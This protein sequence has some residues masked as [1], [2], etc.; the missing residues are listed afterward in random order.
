MLY[1]FYPILGGAKVTI[2]QEL[3]LSYYQQVADINPEHCVYLVQ[4]IRT[5]KFYVKK[6]LTVYNADIYRY[7]MAHPIPNT[8]SILLVEEDEK[9]LTVI[10]EYIPGDT[11]EERLERQSTL[12][13]D[14]VIDITS[15][16]CIILRAFHNCHPAIVNRDIKP[17]NIK[18]SPDGV[19]KLLDLNAAK[20]SSGQSVK[21]TVLLGTQGY[22]A[23]EQYGFGPSSVLTDIY[24]VGVLMNVMLTGELP[25]K[26]VADGRLGTVIRKCVELSPSGRY[27]S[28]CEL[29]AALHP[30]SGKSAAGTAPSSWQKFLPPGFRSR[31]VV[32]WLFS[33]IGYAVLFAVGLELQVKDAGT[34]ELIINRAA[35]IIMELCIVLFNG[36]Y[37]N[38]QKCFF[39]TR[40][41]KR[42][43]RWLGM[44]I[45]DFALLVLWAIITN[46]LVIAFVH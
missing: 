36:N 11:L 31:N 38:V 3:R 39:L 6:L 10:E 20:W 34:I 40:S 27:Q 21:D 42:G 19:V 7:L 23:P 4:N 25:N 35:F 14:Q 33:V 8:P 22:A 46:L 26:R 32:K 45:V 43:I 1:C 16:L 15:Q 37:L 9:L 29:Q 24:A 12:P 18:I 44:G 2:D 17:S 41:R 5:K 28:I 30:S 13:Q